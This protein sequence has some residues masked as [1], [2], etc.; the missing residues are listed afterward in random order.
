MK[1][2]NFWKNKNIFITGIAGF[3]GSNLAKDLLNNGANVIGLDNR[4][5][6]VDSLF[7]FEKID[8]KVNFIFGD[9][10]D[11]K[12]LKN[13]FLKF[14]IQICFHLAA[15]VEVGSANKYPYLTWD[16]NIRGTYTLMEVIRENKKKIKSIIVASSDKAYGKYPIN[17]LPYKENYKLNPEF[18]YDTSKACADIIAKS[19]SSKLFKLPIVITRF[20]NIYGPGQLNFTALIPDA[21]RACLLNKKFIMR[22]DGKAIRDFV[23]IKDIIEL[24]KLLSKNLYLNPKKFSGQIFNAGTNTKHEVKN[25]VKEIFLY[26]KK[27]K[28]LKIIL[29]KTHY[30]KTKGEIAIQYMDYKK[31]NLFLGWRPKYKFKKSLPELFQ[32]YKSY[33]RKNK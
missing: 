10:T 21:I 24:Y 11:K 3:V 7:F 18:P 14:N 19:Y 12:L 30:N 22:S 23:Y 16:T 2:K 5:K 4:K 8:K 13:I 32:W 17:L 9:V 27:K 28:E 6:K 15:Q 1:K 26:S 31:L 33:F 20:A 25:I 29:K